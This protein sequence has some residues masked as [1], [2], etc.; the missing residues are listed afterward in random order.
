[1]FDALLDRGALEAWLPPSGMTA[2]FERF[3]PTPGGS[4]RLVLTH[5]DPTS[6]PGKTTADADVVEARYIDIVV[7][8]RVVQAVDFVADDPAFA[9]TMTMTWALEP[10]GEG[11]LVEITAADVPEGISAEDHATGMRSSL[12]NL[13]S[14]VE[15]RHP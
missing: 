7:N 4:Y 10:S 9:G 11:T 12:A 6:A 15:A 13:A 2:R 3:D 1:V 8:Q 5:A 14:Y